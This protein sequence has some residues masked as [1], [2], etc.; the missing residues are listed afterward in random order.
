[1]SKRFEISVDVSDSEYIDPLVISLVRQ[2]YEVY[3]NSSESLV[4][5]IVEEQ[6]V[7]EIKLDKYY[8]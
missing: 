4:C 1:M 5:F 8:Q 7:T 2:G 3:Y 6:N